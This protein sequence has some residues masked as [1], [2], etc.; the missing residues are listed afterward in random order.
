MLSLVRLDRV[1][2][3]L[4]SSVRPLMAAIPPSAPRASPIPLI[5]LVTPSKFFFCFWDHFF[6]EA[7]ALSRSRFSCALSALKPTARFAIVAIG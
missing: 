5:A 7:P 4:A 2:S 1:V 6:V 3:S